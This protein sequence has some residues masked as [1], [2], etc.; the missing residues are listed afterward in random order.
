MEIVLWII[1]LRLPSLTIRD[2]LHPP[3]LSFPN[4][5]EKSDLLSDDRLKTWWNRKMQSHFISLI[6][7]LLICLINLNYLNAFPS[8][9]PADACDTLVPRH[10]GTYSSFEKSPYYVVASGDSYDSTNVFSHK[11]SIR[12]DLSGAPFKGFIVTA[13][14]PHTGK[15]NCFRLIKFL[16]QL[17]TL[18][19]WFT[20]RRI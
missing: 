14:D 1:S 8:G 13:V 6:S 2:R 4:W 18:I 9:A 10:P 15:Q 16:S 11:T 5:T 12:V 19:H 17:L 7:S 3:K 20:N